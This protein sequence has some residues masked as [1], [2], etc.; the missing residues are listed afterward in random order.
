MQVTA[1]YI[2]FYIKK[3]NFDSSSL[4]GNCR[5]TMKT[6]S[7]QLVK[8]IPPEAKTLG[9]K[10]WKKSRLFLKVAAEFLFI[11]ISSPFDD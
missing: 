2:W 10:H 5:Q 11:L 8:Y 4:Y 9:P 3:A 7:K 1:D 6:K